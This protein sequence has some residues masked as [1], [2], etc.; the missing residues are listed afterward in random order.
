MN[1]VFL[2]YFFPPLKAPRAVQV[3]RLA[4]YSHLPIR[5]LCAA[6]GA[7][8]PRPGVEVKVFPD[9]TPRWWRLAKHLLY[10]PDPQRPWALRLAR[11]V[12]DQGLIGRDDVLVTFGQPM[13]DHLA[14]LY[15]KR[16]LGMRWVAHFSDP[17]S[18][19][20]YLLPLPFARVRLRRMEREVFEAADQLLFTS[21]ETV[22]LVMG[23]YPQS[24]RSKA[25]VLPHA[26]EAKLYGDVMP[27]KPEAPLCIRYLGNFYRQRNPLRFV[28]ALRL[29][30][31]NRPHV[32]ENLRIELIGR[33]VGHA[34]W[35]SAGLGLPE[36]MLSMRRPVSYV[37]SVQ[38]MRDADA[39]LIIDAPFEHNVFFPSKLVDY[40]GARRPI[41]ALTPPGTS[42]D[43][44]VAAGGRVIPPLTVESMADGLAD[45]IASLREGVLTG[46]REEVVAR[47]EANRVA[48]VFD[49]LVVTGRD[50]NEPT[51]RADKYIGMD[52]A[53]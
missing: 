27:R 5:V 10:L 28:E 52:A 6:E 16:R 24:W 17:W 46:P 29:L 30:Q 13:S 49:A 33:W 40:L 35:S 15:L 14:G 22:D 21:R 41:I 32:L 48:A 36:G 34:D 11:Q 19:N 31:K 1:A 47:Y 51:R 8:P 42:A 50:G 53:A 39:L 20:P 7:Q 12:S 43:I 44:V 25:A 26:F 45:A 23:K 9:P 37:E 4:R 38:L 18:D 3:D 2:S